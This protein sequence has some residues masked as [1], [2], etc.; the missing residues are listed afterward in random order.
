MAIGGEFSATALTLIVI[1]VVYSL[2]ESLRGNKLESRAESY[3]PSAP[4]TEREVIL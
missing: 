1:P 3:D 4:A 2:I